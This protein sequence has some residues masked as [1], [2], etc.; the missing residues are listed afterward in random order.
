MTALAYAATAGLIVMIGGL[1]C[2]RKEGWTER[3][4]G[5]ALGGLLAFVFFA[6]PVVT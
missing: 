3:A 2:T 1:A 6:F 5:W 4:S